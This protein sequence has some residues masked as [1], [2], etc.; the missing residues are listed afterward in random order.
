MEC[1]KIIEAKRSGYLLMENVKILI[2]QKEWTGLWEVSCARLLV[3]IRIYELLGLSVN[4]KDYGIPRN[5]ERVFC[6]SILGTHEPL[7]FS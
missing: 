6:V 2:F 3:R 7:C 4:A 5:R 1:E